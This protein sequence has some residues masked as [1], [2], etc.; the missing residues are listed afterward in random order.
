MDISSST[1]VGLFT[2][3][4]MLNSLVPEFLGLPKPANQVPPR[5]QIVGATATV[6]TL[7]TVVGH[8]KTPTSAGNG[9]FN[10]GFPCWIEFEMFNFLIKNQLSN[11][12]SSKLVKSC[13]FAF[14][15]FN[16]SSFFATNVS[17][18]TSVHENVEIEA[19]STCILP[20]ESSLVCLRTQS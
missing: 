8:P 4:E 18:C 15:G 2:C 14:N 11:S 1:V 13:L 9:G 6:S 17:A 12:Q 7:E 5:L 19:G 3:P 16:Q 20:N 10:L